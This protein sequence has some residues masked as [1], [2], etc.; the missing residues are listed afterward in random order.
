MFQILNLKIRSTVAKVNFVAWSC[1]WLILNCL[2]CCSSLSLAHSPSRFHFLY[3]HHF[4]IFFPPSLAVKAR[5]S[6]P[7]GSR[8]CLCMCVWDSVQEIVNMQKCL[9][10]KDSETWRWERDCGPSCL[11]V[12]C[13]SSGSLIG[14]SALS[15][16]CTSHFDISPTW[17]SL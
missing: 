9:R 8:V 2:G 11:C 16:L 7:R 4:S 12:Y 6:V 10:E 15:V 13:H 14:T 17:A 5:G 3:F 1:N